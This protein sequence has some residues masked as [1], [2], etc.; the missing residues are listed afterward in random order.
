MLVDV[1]FEKNI[2]YGWSMVTSLGVNLHTIASL[3]DWIFDANFNKA[4]KLEQ[5]ALDEY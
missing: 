3:N 5:Q 4:I 1:E 2:I